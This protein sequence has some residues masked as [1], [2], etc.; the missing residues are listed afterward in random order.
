VGGAV[1]LRRHLAPV[2]I[3]TGTGLIYVAICY[4]LS[5]LAQLARRRYLAV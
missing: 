4:P 2:E 3:L 5:L 1:A